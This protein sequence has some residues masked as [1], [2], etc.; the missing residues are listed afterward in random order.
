MTNGR[1]GHGGHA[2]SPAHSHPH[3]HPGGDQELD[4]AAMADHLERA[5]EITLASLTETAQWLGDLLAERGTRVRRVLD[6][7][8]G[9]GVAACVFAGAFPGAEVVAVDGSEP[10]LERAALR[11][12]GAGVEAER[13]RTLRVDLPEDFGALGGADLI[14]SSRAVHHLGDQQDAL[15]RL[16]G[17]LR[18][19]GLLA[20]AEGGLP[21]RFLPRDFGL[22]RPGLEA[23]IDAVNG[24]WFTVMRSELPGAVAVVE[25]WPAMLRR[26]GLTPAGSRTFLTDLQAPVDGTVRDY[27]HAHLSRVREVLGTELDE[28]DVPVLDA[29]LDDGS[30]HGVRRRPDLFFLTATTVHTAVR[31]AR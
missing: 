22:G 21:M 26:A 24:E 9:P 5:G 13:F 25:D 28:D 27:L 11:A 16:A 10:L 14:W 30:P 31:S 20:V 23:R 6:V 1:E 17:S 4:W 2:H 15:N 18:D 7:G 29:L 8:S 12:A 3:S 19:G